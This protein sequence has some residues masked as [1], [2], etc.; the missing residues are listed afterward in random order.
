MRLQIIV[1]WMLVLLAC[2]Q[3]QAK[4]SSYPAQT[5]TNEDQRT[6]IVTPD[7]ATG[8]W[9]TERYSIAANG[10]MLACKVEYAWSWREREICRKGQDQNAWLTFK[11]AVPPG[12]EYIGFKYVSV[13]SG[14]YVEIYWKKKEGVK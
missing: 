10:D 3:V 6:G 14:T 13:G 2:T 11:D 9:R 4:G 8:A 12:T 1:G 7:V 5:Q